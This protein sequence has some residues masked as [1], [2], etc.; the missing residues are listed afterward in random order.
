MDRQ[1]L[2]AH[3]LATFNSLELL[4]LTRER[5]NWEGAMRQA[6]YRRVLKFAKVFK[7]IL[8]HYTLITNATCIKIYD[9]NIKVTQKLAGHLALDVTSLEKAK[10]LFK[11]ETDGLAG[12]CLAAGL[13]NGRTTAREHEKLRQMMAHS[14]HPLVL[15]DLLREVMDM[16]SPPPISP[17]TPPADVQERTARLERMA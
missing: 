8:D 13:F 15:T 12:F 6:A 9:I 17:G 4:D 14:R 7:V 11:I 3:I 1:A 10:R 2:V 16:P 5:A